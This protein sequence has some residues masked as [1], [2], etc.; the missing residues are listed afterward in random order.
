MTVMVPPGPVV[1][2]VRDTEEISR[3]GPI[4]VA[5]PRVLLVVRVSTMG[6]APPLALATR[7]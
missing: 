2:G 6:K 7:K 1:M 5:F 3:S 4:R